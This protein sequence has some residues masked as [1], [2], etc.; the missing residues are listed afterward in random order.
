M[1]RD[2]L[3]KEGWEEQYEGNPRSFLSAASGGWQVC[4]FWP[5]VDRIFSC[6]DLSVTKSRKSF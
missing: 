1:Y 3:L 2:G 5:M 4:R 6:R